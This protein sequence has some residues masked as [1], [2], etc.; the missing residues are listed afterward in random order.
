MIRRY[1]TLT[2]LTVVPLIVGGCLDYEEEL[3]LK[4]NGSGE[5]YVHYVTR[6]GTNIESDDYDFPSE[7]DE[8]RQE[9]ERKY[10]S[11]KVK[12]KEFDVEQ[13]GDWRHVSFA[14]K[15]ENLLDLNDLEQFADSQFELKDH[16]R[17]RFDLCRTVNV[18]SDWKE[19]E[20]ESTLGRLAKTFL[21][22]AFMDKVKFRFTVKTPRD[23]RDNNAD[24]IRDKREAVWRFRLTDLVKKGHIDM[25]LECR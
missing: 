18:D 5:L 8:V 21:E 24:W 20:D 16:G 3:T 23:I 14:V 2:V 6:E 19:E 15:F 7:P 10:T 1:L 4:A 22:D 13:K 9:V 12:L 11:D 25:F 17:G